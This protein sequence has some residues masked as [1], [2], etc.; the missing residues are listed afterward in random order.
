MCI[1]YTAVLYSSEILVFTLVCVA[2]A[3]PYPHVKRG[4]SV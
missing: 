2:N 4:F 1:D 3:P